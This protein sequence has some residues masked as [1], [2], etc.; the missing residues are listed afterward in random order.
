MSFLHRFYIETILDIIVSKFNIQ[1]QT[2]FLYLKQIEFIIRIPK[3]RDGLLVSFLLFIITSRLCNFKKQK[4]KVI[5]SKKIYKIKELSVTLR[6][7]EMYDTVFFLVYAALP[8]LSMAEQLDIKYRVEEGRTL[9]LQL[10]NL[11]M[12]PQCLKIITHS[13]T[14]NLLVR[15]FECRLNISATHKR[16]DL[17]QFGFL[18]SMLNFNFR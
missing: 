1:D 4:V 2:D 7:T 11:F 12:F 16:I 15:R 18:L 14:L 13:N 9:M 8:N 10:P 17:K 5:K 6:N 3:K